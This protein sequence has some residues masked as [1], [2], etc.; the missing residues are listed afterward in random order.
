MNKDECAQQ[1]LWKSM[2]LFHLTKG[3]NVKTFEQTHKNS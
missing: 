3:R 1:N 2:K